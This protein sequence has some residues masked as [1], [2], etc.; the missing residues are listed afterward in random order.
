MGKLID[1]YYDYILNGKL[2][3]I[4]KQIVFA[5][6]NDFTDRRG[7]RQE[8]ENIDEDIK[9]EMIQTWIDI[10]KFKLDKRI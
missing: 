8:W 6:L 4:E 3:T 5:I 7:L 10:V 2:V 9:E 1:K